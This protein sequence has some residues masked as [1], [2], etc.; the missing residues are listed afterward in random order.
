MDHPSS[1]HDHGFTGTRPT[2]TEE[3]HERECNMGKYFG[4]AYGMAENDRAI[5]PLMDRLVRP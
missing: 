2:V 5:A 4:C 1:I 3:R